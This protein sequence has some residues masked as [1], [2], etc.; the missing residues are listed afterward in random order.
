MLKLFNII[1]LS[2]IISFN[3]F[4]N[5]PLIP[6]K[7]FTQMPMVSNPSISPD[8]N[9]IA[10]ILNQ[11]GFT[12]V[13]IIPFKN[14]REMTVVVELGEEKY[15]IEEIYWANNNKI[16]V[17]VTQ[18]YKMK[19]GR[20]RITHL[21]SAN[22]DGSN[23]LELRKRNVKTHMSNDPAAYYNSSPHLLSLLVGQPDHILITMSDPRDMNYSSVFKV[24]VNDGTFKKFLP[25]TLRI[26][27]WGVTKT[28]DVLLAIGADRDLNV[29]TRYIYTRKTSD[30]DWVLIKTR[31]PYI[32]D[33]FKVVLFEPESNSIIVISDYTPNK[34]DIVKESLWRYD[35]VTGSYSELLGKA[36]GDYDVTG[37]ISKRTG[38]LTEVIGYKY[39][40]G[41]ERF[42]YFDKEN[43]LLASEISNVFSKNNLVAN[44]YDWDIKKNHFIFST[45]SDSKPTQY[46]LFDK[47][48]KKLKPWYS[49]YPYLSKADL[50]KV[51]PFDFKARDGML[52]HGYLTLPKNVEN[53]PVILYPHGGPFARDTQS[54]DTFVQMFA[55]RGYAVLQVNFRGSTGYGKKYKTSGYMQWGKK[56]QTDLLDAMQWLKETG[57]ANVNNACVVGSSYGGYAA[58]VAGFQTPK[59]F[60]CIISVAGISNM[61]SQ[62]SHW[63]RFGQENYVDNVVSNTPYEMKRVSPMSH[64]SEFTAPVLLIHGKADISVSYYQSEAMYDALIRARKDVELELFQYG[65]HQLNDAVNRAKAMVMIEGFLTKHLN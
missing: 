4:A 62:I 12:K 37:A 22:I 11:G 18:P 30:D 15:R 60:K 21:Y 23:T 41:F 48:T 34:G 7:H 32:S 28:G 47:A 25:N 13:A 38:M 16:L 24:N 53:P 61:R 5:S 54:F 9:N 35:I 46:Y 39:N 14:S 57:Q 3:T 19:S 64:A 51:Q 2:A 31:E 58:L 50:P 59:L 10:V 49:Q 65:T 56:M 29:D 44:L 27:E 20:Y 36:P 43:S 33:T 1:L 8:G 6:L 42:V 17:S 26:V 55:S 63:E 52:L 40:D 45:V